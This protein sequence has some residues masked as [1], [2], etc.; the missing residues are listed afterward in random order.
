M[1][2]WPAPDDST[3]SQRAWQTPSPNRVAVR[4]VVA[5]SL[6]AAAWIFAS[7]RLL[8][9]V[10]PERAQLLL[11]GTAKGLLFILVT[12]AFLYL[13][14]RREL[15]RR[16]ATRTDLD[17]ART[18]WLRVFE[19]F[20]DA[21][22]LVDLENRTFLAANEATEHLTGYTPEEITGKPNRI[23]HADVYHEVHTR[24][25]RAL[26]REGRFSGELRI[27][28]RDGTVRRV[29]ALYLGIGRR[30][31]GALA[32]AIL[33]DLTERRLSEE[34]LRRREAQL[35]AILETH[36]DGVIYLDEEER[37][38]F[39][40]PAAAAL[41]GAAPAALVG[42]TLE[43]WHLLGSDGA[44]LSSGELPHRRACTER[45]TVT[46]M[47]LGLRRPD[48][49]TV[50]I[51]V[52]AAPTSTSYPGDS[53]VVL[54]L[55]DITAQRTAE[56]AIAQSREEL[57]QAQKLESIGRLAGGIAHDFNNSLTV[58]F[59]YGEL[60]EDRAPDTAPELEEIRKAAEHA[61]A[62]TRQLLAFSRKQVLR[63]QVF[64]VNSVITETER[65]IGRLIGE[66]ITLVTDLQP[67]LASIRADPV[68]IQ[69]VLVNLAVNARDAI[70][71]GGT[72]TITTRSVD[73]EVDAAKADPK[74]EAG[75]YVMISVAD[76]GVGIDPANLDLVFEPFFTTKGQEGT[77]LGLSTVYGIVKQSGGEV[78]VE[79]A[80]G[81]GATFHVYLPRAVEPKGTA[82]E[83]ST[84][85]AAPAR[86]AATGLG[87]IL[88]VEDDDRI[89]KLSRRIL[90]QRGYEV[91]SAGSSYEALS[92]AERL[93]D[94]LDLLVTDVILP[95][96]NGGQLA[97]DLARRHAGLR[98]VFMSGYAD[99]VLA[100]R[101]ILDPDTKLLEKPFTREQLCRCVEEALLETA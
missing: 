59:G 22:L 3:S 98:V 14:V 44:P 56:L 5:Y 61:A 90:E 4:V 77:G 101:G 99:D 48:G 84:A 6:L 75:E 35:S 58:I 81:R 80:P 64:D 89:R 28:H 16:F 20:Q 37:I 79:S 93:D 96:M 94:R 38:T 8:A 52:S 72:L 42:A 67:D 51:S 65:M 21:I 39:A 60:L 33:R 63:P 53:G 74:L 9:Y 34:A 7:D 91:E 70:A 68:Q 25:V 62:L 40:N 69:Q 32:V 18:L 86:A 43:D 47:E 85:A 97:E 27:L 50:P 66:D 1:P 76:D 49:Q 15:R 57:R 2:E 100:R 71:D 13:F 78:R 95:G 83:V 29:D 88:L 30:G 26:E 36:A 11:L 54:T 24:L 17:Q 92:L 10:A 87:V 23:L 46:A 31:E 19:N 45:C 12:G 82:R 41:L 55:H 73:V